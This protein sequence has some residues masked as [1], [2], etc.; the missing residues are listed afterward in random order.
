MNLKKYIKQSL[1]YLIEISLIIFVFNYILSYFF[2]VEN[3][4]DYF[5]RS[6]GIYTIYQLF[7][8]STLKLAADAQTDAYSTL[9]SMNEQALLN[10]KYFR[11]DPV[12]Y[13]FSSLMLK[14]HIYL[15]L[16]DY[17]FNMSKVKKEYNKLITDIDNKNSYSI[18]YSIISINHNLSL[19]NRKFQLSFLLRCIKNLSPPHVKQYQNR[20]NTEKNNEHN[21]N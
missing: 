19:I 20:Y 13:F 21:K 14:N 2:P 12:A 16:E 7:V 11:N 4:F 8:Y 17:V 3:Y 15:Q 1:I 18:E 9:K 5:S 10:I 6:L